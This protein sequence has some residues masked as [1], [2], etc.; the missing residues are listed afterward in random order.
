MDTTAPKVPW[1]KLPHYIQ[2]A[3][4]Y[5]WS[6]ITALDPVQYLLAVCW[7]GFIIS[8]SVKLSRVDF[9]QKGGAD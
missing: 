4:E 3:G 8:A 9:T 2:V 1:T 5:A 6:G 7:L